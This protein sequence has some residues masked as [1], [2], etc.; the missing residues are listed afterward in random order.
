MLYYIFKYT[1]R[2][3]DMD[4]FILTFHRNYDKL[5]TDIMD[6]EE[7]HGDRLQTILET[8]CVSEL[9]KIYPPIGKRNANYWWNDEITDSRK[10]TTRNKPDRDPT[11][12]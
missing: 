5:F 4:K 8:I 7:A 2:D 9:K 11:L 1:T 3:A 6:N 10:E 12:M